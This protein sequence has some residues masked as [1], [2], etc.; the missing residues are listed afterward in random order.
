MPNRNEEDVVTEPARYEVSVV[1]WIPVDP[2]APG[3]TP[4][5]D[6]MGPASPRHA[7]QRP[8]FWQRTVSAGQETMLGASEAIAA[9]V[10]AIAERMIATLQA[11]QTD[12]AAALT[13]SGQPDPAWALNEVEVTFGLQLTGETSIAVFSASTESSAEITLRFTQTA[14]PPTP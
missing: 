8:T 12:R 14:K 1:R 4:E 5:P 7:R 13:A 9:E 2:G 6:E 11:R 3:T 10:D